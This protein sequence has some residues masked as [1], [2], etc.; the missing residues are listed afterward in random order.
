MMYSPTE[1]HRK[2]AWINFPS[3]FHLPVSHFNIDDIRTSST[4]SLPPSHHHPLSSTSISPP[5]L[6]LSFFL[7]FDPFPSIS[8][9]PPP[10]P[11]PQ[12]LHPPPISPALQ[13][14]SSPSSSPF[15]CPPLLPPP[16]LPPFLDILLPLFRPSSI[17]P[18]P[19]P[20]S[21]SLIELWSKTRSSKI[22]NISS[23]ILVWVHYP[24]KTLSISKYS[25][26]ME[27]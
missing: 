24:S 19:S 22:F 8:P 21:P 18:S 26:N 11:P 1:D 23:A 17:S 3:F 9:P 10:P 15:P 13:L 4:I 25:G 16:T 7:H 12:T 2:F 27:G 6:P 14:S 5:S 20:L